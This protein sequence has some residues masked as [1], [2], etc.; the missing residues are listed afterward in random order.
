MIY[1]EKLR[2][3]DGSVFAN[4]IVHGNKLKLSWALGGEGEQSAYFVRV[5]RCGEP[6]FESGWVAD[7]RQSCEFSV[8]ALRSGYAYELSLCLR[9]GDGRESPAASANL[10]VSLNEA[11]DTPWIMPQQDF[12]DAVIYFS[13]DFVLE[14][15]IVE[16]AV[17]YVSGIGYH[18]ASINGEALSDHRLAPSHSDYNKRCYYE[19]LDVSHL[20][21]AGENRLEI[22]VAQG[23]RRNP[24]S[25]HRRV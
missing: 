20:L 16:N 5:L 13:R 11:W 7:S 4:T 22:E 2:I 12:G 19:T 15:K 21:G 23:W 6:L 25:R 9:D 18:R 1:P 10:R 17:L 24:C 14:D 8:P 3:N